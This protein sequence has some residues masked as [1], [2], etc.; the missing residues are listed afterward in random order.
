MKHGSALVALSAILLINCVVALQYGVIFPVLPQLVELRLVEAHTATLHTGLIAAIYPLSLFIFAPLWGR[1]SDTH[2]PVPALIVAVTGFS[3]TFALWFL[4]QSLELLYLNRLMSGALVAAV[5]PISQVLVTELASDL[6]KRAQ[7]FSWLSIALNIGYL[8]G[9]AIGGWLGTLLHGAAAL[10]A[11]AAL[12]GALAILSALL[13]WQ[14]APSRL[15]SRSEFYSDPEPGREEI[16]MKWAL[17]TLSALTALAIA[18]FE[19]GMSVKG[20]TEMHLSAGHLGGLMAECMIVM[21]L[22]Q[23][24]VFNTG[25]PV[26][27]SWRLLTP[28]FAI[29][30]V[31]LPVFG[32]S[33]TA[34]ILVVGTAVMAASTGILFPVISYWISMI[35]ADRGLTF[36]RQT[37]A[38]NLGQVLGSVS[39]ATLSSASFGPIASVLPATLGALIG[40]A[41][42]LRLHRS[43]SAT[44]RRAFA[45]VEA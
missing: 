45:R 3:A 19:V 18:T 6:R 11:I 5:F 4:P 36:G 24:I 37:A 39:I 21:I 25:F 42:S 30:L 44:S 28:C 27:H 32:E 2:S 20:R 41:I 15:P 23:A 31:A 35:P 1:W 9:P 43:L 16:T 10:R 33:G 29:L 34:T 12:L 13:F 22:A 26:R 14:F 17:L 40:V 7:M 8:A 38:T